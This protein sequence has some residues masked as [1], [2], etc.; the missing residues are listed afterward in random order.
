MRCKEIEALGAETIYVPGADS[1]L[2]GATVAASTAASGSEFLH[3]NCAAMAGLTQADENALFALTPIMIWPRWRSSK[4]AAP[5]TRPTAEARK[6]K[7]CKSLDP[8]MLKHPRQ[9]GR[10]M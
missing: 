2:A 3:T 9:I 10:V 8:V 4:A 1:E 6:T 5:A 7:T